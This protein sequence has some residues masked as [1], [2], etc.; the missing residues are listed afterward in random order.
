MGLIEVVHRVAVP[1]SSTVSYEPVQLSLK[2]LKICGLP[3][4]LRAVHLIL[5]AVN[6]LCELFI[7][8]F[9]L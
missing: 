2:L 8:C 9:H 6:L 7:L 4:H 1:G 5:Y 3:V